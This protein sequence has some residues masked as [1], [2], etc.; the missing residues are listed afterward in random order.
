[1]S[2]P[3]GIRGFQLSNSMT[4]RRRLA[5]SSRCVPAT[6]CFTQ[7]RSTPLWARTVPANPP[8]SRSSRVSTIAT[9]GPSNWKANPVDFKSTAESKAAGIAVIYQEPTLFPDL[10]V[11]ENIF[12]GRQPVGRFGRIDRKAMRKE[13][14]GLMAR[15]GV[16]SIPIGPPRDC[17]SPTS[18]SSRLPKPSRWTPRF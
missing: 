10:T 11:T 17:R 13:V 3:A 6:L 18:R 1:M 16:R 12:M 8:W 14:K 7:A 5:L 2:Q 15:L 4:S 9:Q